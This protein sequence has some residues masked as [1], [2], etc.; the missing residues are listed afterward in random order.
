MVVDDLDEGVG[1]GVP[2]GDG[3]GGEVPDFEGGGDA[4]SS[5]RR[6]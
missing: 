4:M 1:V 3:E 5:R 6:A 2:E